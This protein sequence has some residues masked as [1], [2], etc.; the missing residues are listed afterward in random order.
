MFLK[1]SITNLALKDKIERWMSLQEVAVNYPFMGEQ[2]TISIGRYCSG[3]YETYWKAFDEFKYGRG[4]ISSTTYIENIYIDAFH[5]A[6]FAQQLCLDRNYDLPVGFLLFE[7]QG[8]FEDDI[9][10]LIEKRQITIGSII[11]RYRPTSSSWIPNAALHFVGSKVYDK[12]GF[13]NTTCTPFIVDRALVAQ[14]KYRNSGC[15]VVHRIKSNNIFGIFRQIM[16]DSMF[17][18]AEVIIQ[19]GIQ[20][21]VTDIQHNVELPVWNYIRRDKMEDPFRGTVIWVDVEELD[22]RRMYSH[23]VVDCNNQ[24]EQVPPL[25]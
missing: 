2:T 23:K 24:D 9:C 25:I 12:S 14:R 22:V 3:F 10:N 21:T 16:K 1:P 13:E 4:K 6:F 18:E 20:L 5:E 17:E 11:E 7:G 8:R 15:L 19:P